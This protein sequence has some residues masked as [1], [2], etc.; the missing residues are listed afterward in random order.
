M[1]EGARREKRVTCDLWEAGGAVERDDG[2]KDR[3]GVVNGAEKAELAGKL[4]E[5]AGALTD[6]Q[7]EQREA[8]LIRETMWTQLDREGMIRDYVV[9]ENYPIEE[10]VRLAQ[11]AGDRDAALLDDFLTQLQ[12]G[13]PVKSYW[14]ATGLL[15][16]VQGAQPA[17]SVIE[18]ALEQVEPWTGIVLAETLIGLD[19]PSPAIRYLEGALRSENLMV[20]LQ[21]METIVETGLVNTALRPTSEDMVP[22]HP[23]QRP[24]DGRRTR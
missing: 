4:K 9:S 7:L 3:D 17:L 20:R 12:S 2:R 15:M 5:V 24:A 8:G 14:A 21:A 23:S 1:A 6:W 16:L 13:H 19:R 18:S 11:A 10:I 22:E